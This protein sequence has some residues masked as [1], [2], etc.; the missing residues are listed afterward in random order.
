MNAS[1]LRVKIQETACARRPH[2]AFHARFGDG[3]H[4]FPCLYSHGKVILVFGPDRS[5]SLR[6]WLASC[7]AGKTFPST[8]LQGFGP[9]SRALCSLQNTRAQPGRVRHRPGTRRLGP[10]AHASGRE[11]W[12]VA[13]GLQRRYPSRR[14]PSRLPKQ[15][16]PACEQV[17][18]AARF[19]IN[20]PH[21]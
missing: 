20:S 6:P 1:K 3:A 2:W 9:F 17:R 19:P 18:A 8:W 7:T 10:S 11:A 14:L 21:P 5:L 4:S 13:P 16:P 15:P 12:R